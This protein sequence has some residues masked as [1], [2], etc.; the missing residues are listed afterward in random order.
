MA[1]TLLIG[2]GGTGSR[3]VDNVVKDLKDRGRGIN[4]GTIG[5]AVLDTNVNDMGKIKSSETGVPV[6]PTSKSMSIDEYLD[7]YNHLDPLAWCPDSPPSF[8]EQNMLDG[9]SQLRI[10]SRLAFMDIM[11]DG[12]IKR[13]EHIIN[14]LLNGKEDANLRIMI[15][16]SLSGG[17][18]S[19]MFI[20]VALWL[21]KFFKSAKTEI[22]IRGIF[23]LPD[24]FVETVH[25]IG[26]DVTDRVRHYANAYA[27]IRE[28]NALSRLIADPG[29]QPEKPI[30]IQGLFD[31]DN[32]PAKP[33]FDFAFFVDYRGARAGTL[34]DIKDYEKIVAQFVYMQLYAP[35]ASDLYSEEDNTFLRFVNSKEPLYGSCGTSKAVYPYEDVLQY[36]ALRATKDSITN[37]WKK[38]DHEIEGMKKEEEEAE[39]DGIYSAEKLDER[40]EY[41]KLF[42]QYTAVSDEKAGRDRLFV[43]IASDTA[44]IELTPSENGVTQN[45]KDKVEG[46]INLLNNATDGDGGKIGAIVNEFGGLDDIC[47]N[48]AGIRSAKESDDGDPSKKLAQV[49]KNHFDNVSIVLENFDSIVEDKAREIVRAVFPLDMGDLNKANEDTV[50]GLLTNKDKDG[51]ITFVHPISARYMIYKL[52]SELNKAK[53]SIHLKD[54]RANALS[55]DESVF[56]NP[57]TGRKK[58]TTIEAFLKSQGLFQSDKKFVQSFEESFTKFVTSQKESCRTYEFNALIKSVYTKLTERLEMLAANI[59]RFFRSLD[60]VVKRIERELVRNVDKNTKASEKILY[61]YATKAHKECIYKKIKVD[62]ARN[63]SKVNESAVR[64][65]Y[66]KVCAEK[67]PNNLANQAFAGIGIGGTFYVDVIEAFRAEIAKENEEFIDF[68]LYT[69]ICK[70]CDFELD[71]TDKAKEDDFSGA[72]NRTAKYDERFQEYINILLSQA[73]PFLIYNRQTPSKETTIKVEGR[74]PASLNTALPKTFWGFSSGLVKAYNNLGNVL[75]V[76]INTQQNDKYGKNELY[77]YSAIY[78]L[79]ASDIPAFNEM[80]NGNYYYSYRVIINRMIR[81]L[82]A[83]EEGNKSALVNTPHLDKRWHEM[84]PYA[85][86]EKQEK[87]ELR[88]YRAFWLAIAYGNIS[89][90]Y[91]TGGYKIERDVDGDYGTTQTEEETLKYNGKVIKKTDIAQLLSA[92]KSDSVFML[93]DIG[94]LEEMFA[95]ECES[96]DSTYVGTKVYSGLL[97]K[98]DHLNP[99]EIVV[100][101]ATSRSQSK[102]V[103]QRLIASL[104]SIA[105]ELAEGLDMVRSK[106]KIEEAKVELCYRIYATTKRSKGV[107]SV[108]N[109]WYKSFV[110]RGFIPKA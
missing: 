22:S 17:T 19:G 51:N 102:K 5:C 48:T 43:K 35:M 100:R 29:Y 53:D 46:F 63:N 49:V 2:L 3:V 34:K 7:A 99:I 1:Q 94:E 90:D 21:R 59:E 68:D 42:D 52:L 91:E 88:F 33:V 78:G 82:A 79:K 25:D 65:V 28:L 76:N 84:L 103:T 20:Q 73:A 55:G 6:I 110:A 108:F 92:L 41:I 86:S 56:D 62:F 75:G 57:F 54:N 64:T 30:R 96:M 74:D 81:D 8:L 13:L 107:Q 15:V 83:A 26:G 11:E 45:R 106:E 39:E 50:Y 85:S 71:G 97:S 18:G 72:V 27:A 36:C 109:A 60:D 12:T 66:G 93:E 101:Y 95:S 67:R 24:I 9:A 23:L 77:C 58:E 40:K 14:E 44:I 70:E 98:N 16:S 32:R 38:I 47:V 80:N 31:S 4:D 61:V 69:A 87:E 37:G 104:E 89:V 10:K 105:Q